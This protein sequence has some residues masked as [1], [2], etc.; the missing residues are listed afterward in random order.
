[1]LSDSGFAKVFNINGGLTSFRV[2]D[3]TSV[4]N[5]LSVQSN[6]PYT[7]ISPGQLSK[8][9]DKKKY[10]IIDLRED[11]SFRSISSDESKN[12]MGRFNNSINIPFKNL[13]NNMG[14][15]KD[16]KDILL[17]DEY[18]TESVK[19]AELLSQNGFK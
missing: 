1:M 11:S 5:L 13:A 3:V 8:I 2:N 18:G 9:I 7:Y 6:L 14:M 16:R 4:C 19:G 10:T 15:I 17:V 12:A